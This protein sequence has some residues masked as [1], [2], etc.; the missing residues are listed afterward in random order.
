VKALLNKSEIKGYVMG[1][2]TDKVPSKEKDYMGL[3]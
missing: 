2:G 3:K 1:N